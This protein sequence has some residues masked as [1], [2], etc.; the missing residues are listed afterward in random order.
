MVGTI[1]KAT[2]QERASPFFGGFW[3]RTL[4]FY[5]GLPV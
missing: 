2:A 5:Y 4:F 1:L 3:E